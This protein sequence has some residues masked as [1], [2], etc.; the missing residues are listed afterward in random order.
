MKILIAENHG[1][2]RNGIRRV[3]T[4]LEGDVTTVEAN[5]YSQTLVK[6]E[7]ESDIGAVVIDLAVPGIPWGEGLQALR[8]KLAHDVPIIVMSPSHDKRQSPALVNLGAAD[9]AP[10]SSNRRAVLSALRMAFS[11]GAER[12]PERAD[13]DEGLGR[14]E[15]A[16]RFLTPRQREVLTLLA[17][18]KSNKE[19]AGDL[20]LAEGTV[21]LHVTAILKALN[22]N[23]RTRAVVAAS[24]LGLTRG[25]AAASG[26]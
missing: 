8:Q 26:H 24:Q 20:H 25:K 11:N 16:I 14:H 6:A 19:I 15:D 7:T 12:L 18:G 1:L 13:S 9:S 4:Q 5:D 3:L 23:N 2:F 10:L 17:Q 22:V 21:K